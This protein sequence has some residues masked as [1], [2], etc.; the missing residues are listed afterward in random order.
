M[1]DNLKNT[2]EDRRTVAASQEHEVRHF[3]DSFCKSH[4]GVEA[5]Q[6]EAVLPEAFKAIAPS[7]SREKLTAVERMLAK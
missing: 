4:P 1:S 7:E 6:V 2:P 3:I 5:G